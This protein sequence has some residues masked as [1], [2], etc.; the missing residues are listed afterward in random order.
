VQKND[1]SKVHG[2]Q[3]RQQELVR[4]S[5]IHAISVN[6]RLLMESVIVWIRNNVVSEKQTIAE[7]KGPFDS[8]ICC[9]PTGSQKHG[10]INL[11]ARRARDLRMPTLKPVHRIWMPIREG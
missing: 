11:N 8:R 6:L 7:A 9:P 2:Q 5:G 3:E 10:G 4:Q 1:L